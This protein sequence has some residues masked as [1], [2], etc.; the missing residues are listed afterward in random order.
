MSNDYDVGVTPE[1]DGQTQRP[2]TREPYRGPRIRNRRSGEVAIWNGQRYVSQFDRS[3]LTGPEQE[4]ISGAEGRARN[5]QQ[6]L[7]SLNRFEELNRT[8]PTGAWF[9]RLGQNMPTGPA[10]RL[11][12]YD[13]NGSQPGGGPDEFDEMRSINS[14]LA[15]QQ[16]PPGSGSSSNIDVT[17]F[18]EGLPNVDRGG[19][20]N[21]RIIGQYRNDARDA[22]DY[23]DF[24]NWYWPARGTLNGADAMYN[25]YR[26]ARARN[27]RL[28]WQQ[29][30]GGEQST[31]P[32]RATA[33][34]Q[35]PRGVP[36]D[37]VWNPQTR[38]W[39]R[40]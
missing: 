27:P 30:I 38:T 15:P 36:A 10:P 40:P 14:R 23:S 21:S 1:S 19:P 18:R 29:H 11:F 20:A 3:R 28:T 4:T 12:S 9:Q 33:P 2:V 34:P 31:P 37:A 35:R 25:E 8:V 26:Q 13:S 17:M 7:P 32:A 22:Q 39:R 16:R 6:N 24:L 5:F